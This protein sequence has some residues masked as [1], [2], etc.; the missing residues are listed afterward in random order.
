M[1][2][3]ILRERLPSASFPAQLVSLSRNFGSF[4]A[5]AAGLESGTGDYFAVLAADLQEPPELVAQF[6]DLLFNCDFQSCLPSR[7]R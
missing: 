1:D 5:I 6:R 2:D 7:S 3:E 4:S